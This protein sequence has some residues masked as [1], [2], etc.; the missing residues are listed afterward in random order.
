LSR[1]R[2][3]FIRSTTMGKAS[4]APLYAFRSKRM[5][6]VYINGRTEM[7]HTAAFTQ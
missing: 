7:G 2:P 6:G 4:R 3:S 5:A 1:R